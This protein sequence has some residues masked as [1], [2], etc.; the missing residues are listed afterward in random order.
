MVKMCNILFIKKK[1]KNLMRTNF[2]QII[3]ETL[4]DSIIFYS[5]CKTG[6]LSLAYSETS[7]LR[8]HTY[9]LLCQ[10][11][12]VTPKIPLIL[13]ASAL[14]TCLIHPDALLMVWVSITWRPLT[15]AEDGITMN[16][17]YMGLL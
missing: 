3:V 2:W 4:Q 9:L 1:K 8:N 16:Y 15:T 10:A 6:F 11:S 13:T 7:T 17:Y 14:E 5:L 12:Y